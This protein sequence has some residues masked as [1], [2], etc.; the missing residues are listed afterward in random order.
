M[1]LTM[2]KKRRDRS[3]LEYEYDY[4]MLCMQIDRC[5][6]WSLGKKTAF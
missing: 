5:L 3:I 4:S 6:I 1:E 2:S